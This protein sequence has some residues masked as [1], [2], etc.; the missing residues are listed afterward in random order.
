MWTCLIAQDDH[1]AIRVQTPA[2]VTFDFMLIT[3][4]IIVLTPSE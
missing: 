4:A 1:K 2:K 3:T